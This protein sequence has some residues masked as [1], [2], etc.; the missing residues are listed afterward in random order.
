MTWWPIRG[1]YDQSEDTISLW[2]IRWHDELSKDR[3]A[4]KRTLWWNVHLQS[5]SQIEMQNWNLNL[6]FGQTYLKGISTTSSEFC[7]I[8]GYIFLYILDDNINATETIN[9]E[10]KIN[11]HTNW[12]KIHK[13]AFK[14]IYLKIKSDWDC[15]FVNCL[16]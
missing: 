16:P 4:N 6:G 11:I 9:I 3:M 12:E 7:F 15:S 13:Y 14:F 10:Q 8:S 5:Q 1:L 2:A